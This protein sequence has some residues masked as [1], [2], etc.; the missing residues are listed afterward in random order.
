MKNKSKTPAEVENAAGVTDQRG[1]GV[2]LG[3][4]SIIEMCRITNNP[5]HQAQVKVNQP[6]GKTLES[7]EETFFV[8]YLYNWSTADI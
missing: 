6:G 3:N 8:R 2:E 7:L 5:L 4:M 1:S